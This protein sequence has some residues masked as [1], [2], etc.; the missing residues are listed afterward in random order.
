MMD[1]RLPAP[2]R[3]LVAAANAGD[4]EAFLDAFA[5]DGSVNDWGRVFT[6]RDA[7]ARWSDAEFVGVRVTLSVTAVREDG[8][9]TV[10]TADV[11]GDGFDGQSDF[12]FRVA[13]D[14][15]REMR[16]SG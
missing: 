14:V 5:A 10:V 11:G 13:G 8:D 7:I 6:G 12:S 15:V 9:E 3:R 4:A 16:I 1:Q 2:V